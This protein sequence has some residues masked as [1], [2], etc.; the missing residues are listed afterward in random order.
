MLT[1]P[2][3]VK[4]IIRLLNEAG[5]E[6]YAVGGCVRDALLDKQPNDW[7]LTTS[8]LPEEIKHVF[9]HERVIETGI[10]HGTVTVLFGGEGYEITTYRVDGKYTDHRRPDSVQFVSNLKEDLMR[11]DFTVNAMAAHPEEGIVDLFGGKDDLENG[12]IRAVGNAEKRFT[13]DALRILRAV[14]FASTYDF[15]ID[16]ETAQA[17]LKLAPTLENVS[18][19]RIFVEIKKLLCGKGAERVLI[20][21]PEILFT[22]LP[23]LRPM[24][25]LAQVNPHHAYD[26]WTHTVKTIQAAPADPILR[27]TMLFHDAG[28]PQKKTTDEKGIDH[29]IGHPL[30]SRDIAE[31]A[32]L[33]LKSDRATIQTVTK[34]VL[35]HDLRV[36][37][38]RINIRRQISRIGKDLFPLLIDVIRADFMG[39]NPAMLP[40]KLKYTDALLREYACAIKENACLTLADMKITG[41]DLMELGAKGKL[42]G[43]VLEKLLDDVIREK[44]ENETAALKSRAKMRIASFT[45]NA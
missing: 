42:I 31:K 14:R 18:E 28:K 40:E 9:R 5:Y 37:E 21:Y 6:A 3:A 13:E 41:R 22:V 12:V 32:L 26:V 20:S 35:E 10:K 29:F 44:V 7:D 43:Q 39:Q 23:E 34:L 19:E 36:P 24:H 25:N 11:R 45:A 8:A 27:L 17:A 33:R 16:D 4:H 2:E 30:A 1:F 38:K 15:T